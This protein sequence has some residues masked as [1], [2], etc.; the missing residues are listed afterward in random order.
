MRILLQIQIE[1]TEL[2]EELN[3]LVAADADDLM[4]RYRLYGFTDS[5]QVDA[6]QARL[7]AHIKAKLKD[8]C[9][10]ETSNA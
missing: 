8:Y 3:N 4:M 1:L 10:S 6:T 2:E 9:K 7:I 5:D